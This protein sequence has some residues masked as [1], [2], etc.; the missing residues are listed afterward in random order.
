[1]PLT[2]A[3]PRFLQVLGAPLAG[4]CE[5]SQFKRSM[6]PSIAYGWQFWTI[7][8]FGGQLR[9]PLAQC[10]QIGAAKIFG[11]HRH[12][13]LDVRIKGEKPRFGQGPVCRKDHRD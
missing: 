7:H 12:A 13:K 1:M 6:Q 11:C 4:P 3:S 5:K 9:P 8:N 2:G 10:L